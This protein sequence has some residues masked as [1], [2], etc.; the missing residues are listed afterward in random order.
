MDSSFGSSN[1]GLLRQAFKVTKHDVA[2]LILAILVVLLC[3]TSCLISYF[4]VLKFDTLQGEAV[5]HNVKATTLTAM[6]QAMA[7]AFS[8]VLAIRNFIQLSNGPVDYFT[9]FLPLVYAEG[10]YPPRITG[11]YISNRV[12]REDA[13]DFTATIRARG[14][15]Y[16]Q[17][18]MF[19]YDYRNPP[20]PLDPTQSEYFPIVLTALPTDV[21]QS[22]AINLLGWDIKSFVPTANSINTI[23]N[24]KKPALSDASS[25]ANTEVI[26]KTTQVT[27]AATVP[28]F[29]ATTKEV[30]GTVGATIVIGQV[31]ASVLN[32]ET[33]NT[34]LITIQDTRHLD[35][36]NNGMIFSS[37]SYFK[38]KDVKPM[39]DSAPFKTQVNI[40][41]LD[42]QL[43]VTF[44]P[45]NNFVEKN[46]G[47]QRWTGIIVSVIACLILLA[48]CIALFFVNK[49]V[50]SYKLRQHGKRHMKVLKD[51]YERT[52]GLLDRLVRQE[53]KSR[54][55]VDAVPDFVI[56]LS[57]YGRVLETNKHF[58]TLFGFT[59]TQIENGLPVNL[60]FKIQD[61][62]F[63]TNTA[64]HSSEKDVFLQATA[65]ANTGE[66]F[67]IVMLIK[68]I[69]Y[70]GSK[71]GEA[72]TNSPETEL[73]EKNEKDAEHEAYAIIGRPILQDQTREIIQLK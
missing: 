6:D 17:F 19:K 16:S 58:D 28:L 20:V 63:Y 26:Q 60:I 69:E 71:K 8:T 41:Y 45:F 21:N 1:D 50:S 35:D 44:T 49:L 14:G 42:V 24:T 64:N 67:D 27:V 13:D 72:V 52:R 46:S 43:L 9:Q 15:A 38:Y 57:K 62:A 11:I 68:D 65:V 30:S 36:G 5:L 55:I 34:V 4:V 10:S 56:V 39:L 25:T 29:N 18:S 23:I 47:T 3:L 22:K 53:S 54:G 59:E 12:K 61:S 32:N 37:N 48:G 33:L 70:K 2:P 40:T 7:S 51:S 73:E 31:L 66:E